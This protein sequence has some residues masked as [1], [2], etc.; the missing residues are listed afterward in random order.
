MELL[1]ARAR[2]TLGSGASRT[3]EVGRL[4]RSLR[5]LTTACSPRWTSPEAAASPGGPTEDDD[6]V[7]V[8]VLVRR[9]LAGDLVRDLLRHTARCALTADEHRR[10]GL[11]RRQERHLADPM[12]TC[13]ASE[14][15]ALGWERY[16]RVGIVGCVEVG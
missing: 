13:A 4:E 15:E 12:L 7:P 8:E 1:A 2:G 5:D 10:I 14:L 6:V 16:R 9:M 11:L 3:V